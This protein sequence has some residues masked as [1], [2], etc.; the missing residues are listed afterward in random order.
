[1]TR[2]FK[3]AAMDYFAF[4]QAYSDIWRIPVIEQAERIASVFAGDFNQ[5]SAAI[6]LSGTVKAVG[7]YVPEIE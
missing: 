5:I 6:P 7:E 4:M 3:Y 2:I 1:M